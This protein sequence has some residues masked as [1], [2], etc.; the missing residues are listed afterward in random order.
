VVWQPGAQGKDSAGKEVDFRQPVFSEDYAVLDDLS[1]NLA[2][3]LFL[4]G[5][6]FDAAHRAGMATVSITSSAIHR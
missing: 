6:L 3:R 5:T 1:A 2:G 4:A